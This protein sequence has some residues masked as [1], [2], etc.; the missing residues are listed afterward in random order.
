MYALSLFASKHPQRLGNGLPPINVVIARVGFV[1]L[2]V[3]SK[4]LFSSHTVRTSK[5]VPRHGA[6]LLQSTN[7]SP[8]SAA[9]DDEIPTSRS[10]R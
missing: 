4:L 1:C 8:F 2:H 3:S 10:E 9:Q 5:A 6:S 7:L